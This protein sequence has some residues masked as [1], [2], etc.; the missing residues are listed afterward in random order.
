MFRTEIKPDP[1]KE[2]LSLNSGILTLGSCFSDTIGDRLKKF[3]FDAMVNPF[4]TIY[5]PNAI[6]NL[7]EYSCSLDKEI[8]EEEF[9][10]HQDIWSHYWFHSKLSALSKNDLQSLIND[11]RKSVYN[12]LQEADWIFITLG[13]A[14]GYSLISNGNLVANCHKVPQ[15]EF[16]TRL[17]YQEEIIAGF[18][19]IYPFIRDKN[20]LL[21]VSPVRHLKETL[22]LNSVSKSILRTV[23]HS[24]SE[25]FENVH[26]FPAYELLLDDLRDYRFYDRDL[27]HPSAEAED[28]IWNK[29]Q[30]SAIDSKS[31]E[32]MTDWEKILKSLSH[33]PFYPGSESNRKF[34]LDL[35]SKIILMGDKVDITNELQLVE[36]K[37]S[38]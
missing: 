27:L 14:I 26:Y 36:K 17:Y 9:V 19:K 25:S 18:K 38:E 12:Y 5:H 13:T 35:K 23:S 8:S 10:Q 33:R 24:L 31:R 11:V 3:K 4:G 32:I 29:F 6:F 20:I 30:D 15:R 37:L 21:T 7:I 34:L 2:K 22:I 16:A 1:L 28:Y